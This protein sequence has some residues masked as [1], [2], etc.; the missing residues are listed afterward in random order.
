[1]KQRLL[2]FFGLVL[3]I[4]ALIACGDASN[5]SANNTGTTAAPPAANPTQAPA[6]HF[7]KG[8]VVKVGSWQVT[9]TSVS[10]STGTDFEKP[11]SG[12]LFLL[13]KVSIVNLSSSEQTFSS[14]LSFTFRDATGEQLNEAFLSTGGSTPEGKVEAG[15]KISGTLTYQASKSTRKGT[16]AF[17]ADITSSG[18]TIWDIT[19]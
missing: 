12:K 1:M 17:Q 3:V 10:T 4:G 2:I 8:D 13:I 5:P 15:S 7:K 14:A 16:L 19:W 9:V 11:D 6:A 18:Q